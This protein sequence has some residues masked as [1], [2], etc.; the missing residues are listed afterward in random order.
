M[1]FSQ[2]FS[3]KSVQGNQKPRL[4]DQNDHQTFSPK[5][6]NHYQKLSPKWNNRM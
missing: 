5:P 4:K 6:E 1:K 2:I 3:P